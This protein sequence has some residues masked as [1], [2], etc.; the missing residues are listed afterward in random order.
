MLE[1][2][3]Q[4][5]LW[6]WS[7]TTRQQRAS[8]RTHQR[9]HR[10]G[11]PRVDMLQATARQAGHVAATHHAFRSLPSVL[12][13]LPPTHPPQ[14]HKH[15]P[16][17]QPVASRG[18]H[19]VVTAPD[20]P[21]C[22]VRAVES[23]AVLYQYDQVGAAKRKLHGVVRRGL[24]AQRPGGERA[25]RVGLRVEE[26]SL[27]GRVHRRVHH[28]KRPR[29]RIFVDQ[30][31]RARAALQPHAPNVQR[32]TIAELMCPRSFPAL[33]SLHPVSVSSVF[34]QTVQTPLNPL[35]RRYGRECLVV[36]S[37]SKITLEFGD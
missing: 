17:T 28:R 19:G 11:R 13:R 26:P 33:I 31:H 23:S 29:L 10:A 8:A 34:I 16:D 3:C 9:G 15:Q 27:G 30:Q 32:K 25:Q 20:P 6:R 22:E 4:R 37:I 1:E 7:W 21:P 5:T 18:G 2:R 35:S 12:Y 24:H 36:H 14:G